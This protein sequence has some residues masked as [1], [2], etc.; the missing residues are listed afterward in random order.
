MRKVSARAFPVSHGYHSDVTARG[1][2]AVNE[3]ASA[4]RLVVRMSGDHHYRSVRQRPRRCVGKICLPEAFGST[5]ITRVE[6]T[7]PAKRDSVVVEHQ[8]Y[9]YDRI[10][11]IERNLPCADC[12]VSR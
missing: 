10:E 8:S 4:E 11:E 7:R 6:Y 12:P 3:T 9:T 1:R 5:Q 2:A